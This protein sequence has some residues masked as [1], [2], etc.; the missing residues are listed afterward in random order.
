[1]EYQVLSSNRIVQIL[2]TFGIIVQRLT[3]LNVSSPNKQLLVK[4]VAVRLDPLTWQQGHNHHRLLPVLVCRGVASGLII[5]VTEEPVC[6]RLTVDTHQAR[7][8]LQTVATIDHKAPVQLTIHL[9]VSDKAGH[10]LPCGS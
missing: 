4:V 3:C 10:N 5:P 8:W 1:M 6:A 2:Q 9:P 7:P